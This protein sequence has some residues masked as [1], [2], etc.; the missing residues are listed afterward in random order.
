[1]RARARATTRAPRSRRRGC[2]SGR[3]SSP[4]RRAAC[5]VEVGRRVVGGV[6]AEHDERLH[7]AAAQRGGELREG[8]AASAASASVGSR[9]VDGRAARCRAP[10]SAP[11]TAAC[12]AGRLARP[13]HDHATCPGWRAGP[14]RARGARPR[15]GPAPSGAAGGVDREAAASGARP[16][17]PPRSAGIRRAGSRSRWSALAPVIEKTASTAQSRFIASPGAET[18]RPRR[19]AAR[20]PDH[21][22]VGVQEV[23]V[24]REDRLRLVE[25]V[26]GQQRAAGG[27][28][29]AGE[30]VR[31]RHGRVSHDARLRVGL[32]GRRRAARERRRGRGRRDDREPVAPVRGVA[33]SR[34]PSRPATKSAQAERSPRLQHAAASGRGRRGRGSRPARGRSTRRG[35]PGAARC[36]RSW[37]AGPRGSRP[38]RP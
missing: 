13:G 35:S 5:E 36:P 21:L 24:D 16:R 23:G 20:V 38:R 32:R 6:A 30:R 33:A 11:A 2:R 29:D 26:H 1:M 8:G 19:E 10:R 17:A 15:P 18:R 34:A 3:R 12:T 14:R 4:S 9:Y 7:L 22:R 31:L 28:R 25:V 37:W 27:A